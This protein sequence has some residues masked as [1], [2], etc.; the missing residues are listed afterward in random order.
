MALAT[1]NRCLYTS[2]GKPLLTTTHKLF[3]LLPAC[4]QHVDAGDKL[5]SEPALW[6]E[7]GKLLVQVLGA[8]F[9]L[10]AFLFISVPQLLYACCLPLST[11]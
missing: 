7:C 10:H 4:Y 1:L 5:H 6:L 8:S 2:D 3:S 9:D 11:V